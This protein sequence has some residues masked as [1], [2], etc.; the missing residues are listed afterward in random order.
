MATLTGENIK[1]ITNDNEKLEDCKVNY[2]FINEEQKN[3]GIS[4]IAKKYIIRFPLMAI[5]PFIFKYK[6]LDFNLD[7]FY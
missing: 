3:I 7:I 6:F 4:D 1:I 5:F 2:Y